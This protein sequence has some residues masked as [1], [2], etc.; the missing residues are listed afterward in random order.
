MI[1]MDPLNHNTVRVNGDNKLE[2]SSVSESIQ[3]HTSHDKGQAYQINDTCSLANGTVVC[4]HVKN[5]STNKDM[6]ISYIRAQIVSPTGGTAPPNT[7]AY[8][9][10]ALGRTWSSGGDSI[11]PVNMNTGSGNQAE[12]AVYGNGPTLSGTAIEI[13]REY[14]KADAELVRFNKEGAL[15]LGPNDTVEVSFVGDNTGGTGYARISF[16]MVERVTTGSGS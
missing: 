11:I 12:T 2:V 13:D 16:M 8:V 3:H 4:I 10:V 6:V 15:I 5:T 14:W 9:Q 1:L 7:S